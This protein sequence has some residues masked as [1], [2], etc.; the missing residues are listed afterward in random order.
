MY[1]LFLDDERFPQT[2]ITL[3]TENVDLYKDNNDWVIVR[4]YNEFVDMVNEMGM[5]NM[6]S[7]DHDLADINNDKEKTGFDAA[8]WLVDYCMDNDVKL[9][10]YQVHSANPVG[11]ENIK[12]YLEN[13][14]RFVG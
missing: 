13:F 1:N 11:K 3:V 12:S 6:V 10:N 14:S 2:A 4:N 9:P 7:F 5:P 8:K